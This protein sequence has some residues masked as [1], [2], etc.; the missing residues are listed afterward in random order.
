MNMLI[1]DLLFVFAPYLVLIIPL[2]SL[3]IKM[4]PYIRTLT[5]ALG[6]SRGCLGAEWYQCVARMPN[7]TSK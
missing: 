1:R 3:W 2:A 5:A 6:D 4:R 7:S